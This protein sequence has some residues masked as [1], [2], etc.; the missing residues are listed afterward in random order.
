MISKFLVNKFS[1]ATLSVN[2]S[3]LLHHK[4]A[5][6]PNFLTIGNFQEKDSRNVKAW[7]KGVSIEDECIH[8]DCAYK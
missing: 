1:V 7:A 8:L 5:I 6:A 2:R 3:P 4:I